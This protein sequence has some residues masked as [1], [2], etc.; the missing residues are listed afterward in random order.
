MLPDAGEEPAKFVDELL[1]ISAE[2]GIRAVLP[3][4]E[5]DL[6]ALARAWERLGNL[7]AGMPSLE[8][9][10]RV[11]D[12]ARMAVVG[13]EVGLR[14]PQTIEVERQRLRVPN[15]LPMPAIVKPPQSELALQGG[16]IERIDAQSARSPAE[17]SALADS[18]ASE[19]VLIQPYLTGRLGAICGVAWNGGLVCAVHQ[20]AHRIWPAD[21]GVSAYAET[22]VADQWLEEAVRRLLERID[23]SGIFEAQFL[24]T[25]QGPYLIDF[26]PRIYGSMALATAAGMNLPALWMRL[27]TGARIE[28]ISYRAGVR[29]RS[30]ELDPRALLHLLRRGDGRAAAR[31]LI[32]HRKT[33]HSVL[34]LTDPLP[35]LASLDKIRSRV[36]VS[37]K[38]EPR[39]G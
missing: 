12:K 24:H 9:V 34:S 1:E 29:Y 35:A 23:W 27:V 31:G 7:A 6:V 20:V 16:R 36:R 28:R 38:P 10:L 17:L 33:A 22:V 4:L 14:V 3:G 39:F 26:N 30:D 19:R 2:H 37:L 11:T 5:R 32:P 8:A 18:L 15:G 21:A 25:E 13:A